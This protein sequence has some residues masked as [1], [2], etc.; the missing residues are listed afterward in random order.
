MTP[1]FKRRIA[2]L[3]SD[4]ESGASEIL[5]EALAIR[6]DALAAPADLITIARAL[7]RAQPTM[8]PIWNAT[9]AALGAR[10]DPERFSRFSQ[11]IVRAPEAL[12]RFALECFNGAEHPNVAG[13]G[14]GSAAPLR[15]VT[16]SFSRSVARVLEVV[17]RARPLRVACSESRPA[18]EGRRLA[19][20]LARAG[21]SVTCFTDAAIGHALGSADAVL[22]GADA[23]A[24]EW[25]M[26]KS[27][28]RML[29]ATAAQQG[30]PL[31]VLAS[32]DKFVS[33]AVASRL[34]I[35]EGDAA[36]VWKDAPAGVALRNPY[37]EPTPLDLVTSIITDAGVLGADLAPAVCASM[38]DEASAGLMAQ[39]HL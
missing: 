37:F 24:P 8:A 10:D 33:H 3:A 34:V 15:L 13:N 35:R 17:G 32:R 11:R 31:H 2:L 14:R 19:T 26:N 38:E 29:A 30:I 20:H 16:I 23:V 27:G 1:E 18:L 4:R 22:V 36:E 21:I 6:R 25:F 28:T 5:E 9:L 7:C 12:A 39:L